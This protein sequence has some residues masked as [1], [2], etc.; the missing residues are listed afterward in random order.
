MDSVLR[1]TDKW[2]KGR[3][4]GYF[5]K[6]KRI[7]D[8]SYHEEKIKCKERS[9]KH[10]KR[11]LQEGTFILITTSVLRNMDSSFQNIHSRS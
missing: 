10:G 1:G 8:F 7:V 4:Q 9:G 3:K 5:D 11:S 2:G 6:L